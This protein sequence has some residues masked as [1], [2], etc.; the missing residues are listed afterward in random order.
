MKG[1]VR[2]RTTVAL[3]AVVIAQTGLIIF[4]SDKLYMRRKRSEGLEAVARYY[5]DMLIRNRVPLT[6]Y[7]LIALNAILEASGVPRKE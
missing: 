7:D 2:T 1:L 5:T 6:D 3:T 4:M